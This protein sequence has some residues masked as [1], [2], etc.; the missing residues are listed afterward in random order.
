MQLT[1]SLLQIRFLIITT[2]ISSTL[3][4]NYRY[5]FKRTVINIR[6]VSEFQFRNIRNPFQSPERY[7][8]NSA[9][10]CWFHDLPDET[11]APLISSWSARTRRT[12][13]SRWWS[14]KSRQPLLP[15]Q[16]KSPPLDPSFGLLLA[17]LLVKIR[18][19]LY[20]NRE[21]DHSLLSPSWRNRYFLS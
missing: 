4:S 17:K 21:L 2:Q 18:D 1:I 20:R 12:W 5:S 11:S 19:R 7:F 8:S 13:T 10:F 14:G 16:S 6:N 9:Y 15:K 3:L